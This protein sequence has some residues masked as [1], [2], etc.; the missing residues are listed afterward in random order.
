[1]TTSSFK[2]ASYY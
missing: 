2:L 1:M